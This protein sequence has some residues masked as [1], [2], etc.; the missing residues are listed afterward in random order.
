M[1]LFN[2]PSTPEG[3]S[4]FLTLLGYKSPI[5][6]SPRY[7][8]SDGQFR[9]LIQSDLM[10]IEQAFTGKDFGRHI[11][12]F[13]NVYNS[14]NASPESKQTA[15]AQFQSSSA[16]MVA[17][18]EKNYGAMFDR[19]YKA[20]YLGEEAINKYN[21]VAQTYQKYAPGAKI[22]L[23]G[24]GKATMTADDFV[25]EITGADTQ[26][27]KPGQVVG[28][29]GQASPVTTPNIQKLVDRA[30]LS[31]ET[32][33]LGNKPWW[34]AEDQATREGAF[35]ELQRITSS[36][37]AMAD[38]VK[39]KGLTNLQNYSW[40]RDSQFKQDAWKLIENSQPGAAGTADTAGVAPV[41]P[42]VDGAPGAAGSL[43]TDESYQRALK[44]LEANPDFQVLPPSLQDLY[45]TALKN[46]DYNKEVNIQGVLDEF[47]RI[48]TQT[49]DPRFSQEIEKFTGDLR[50]Q[51]DFMAQEREMA[52]ETERANAGL[53]IRQAKE[54]LA[55][56]GMTFTGKAIEDLGAESA[57]AQ[58]G[59]SAIP[60]Q[61]PFG[62]LFYEGNVNQ[63]N[64]LMSSSSSLRYKR[65]LE[66]LGQQ[67][68]GV[69]GGQQAAALN[70][71]GFTPSGTLPGTVEDQKQQL[72]GNTLSQLLGQNYQQAEQ[73]KNLQ[74]N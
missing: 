30:L 42:G 35:N 67:A 38:Y 29:A 56:S 46:Y 47:E 17:S 48:K 72:M 25:T 24:S 70:I 8:E 22:K 12:G 34:T 37:Q 43:S 65:A 1:A 26:G 28:Q 20:G 71:P 62:G 40:W 13:L 45:R 52:L 16:S 69:L 14:P 18:L 64:R 68:E 4:K 21:S 2:L 11:G 51:V 10:R 27:R 39:S 59:D 19:M 36:P 44:E 15:L 31:N 50:S 57:Y 60:T 5:N 53:S 3:R 41:T 73:K 7:L 23:V 33:D 49:I 74:Y 66:Q 6:T 63:Q 9:G 54:G 61:T 58:E 32:T 55:K